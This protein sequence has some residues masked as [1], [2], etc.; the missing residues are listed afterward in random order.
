M[1]YCWFPQS[2]PQ[3]PDYG[4]EVVEG[5]NGFTMHILSGREHLEARTYEEKRP[6]CLNCVDLATGEPA[7]ELLQIHAVTK[8]LHKP[9]PHF[10]IRNFL[11]SISERT[12][13]AASIERC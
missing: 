10:F 11:L 12:V 3:Q 2:G 9:S 5:T 6:T 1:T 8:Q 13:D 7:R 4:R